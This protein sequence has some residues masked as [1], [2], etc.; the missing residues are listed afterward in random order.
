MFTLILLLILLYLYS[1]I[2]LIY[3]TIYKDIWHKKEDSLAKEVRVSD[4]FFSKTENVVPI[5]QK[6]AHDKVFDD[7]MKEG[8]PNRHEDTS[9]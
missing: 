7:L 3:F 8:A 1:Y 5:K 9:K 2:L 6:S 4:T